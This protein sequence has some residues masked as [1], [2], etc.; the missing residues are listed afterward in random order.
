MFHSHRRAAAGLA[1]MLLLTTAA[2]RAQTVP[3]S[4]ASTAAP[5]HAGSTAAADPEDQQDIRNFIR[6]YELVRQA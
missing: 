6:V 2:G 3:A 4:A 5:A 1:I